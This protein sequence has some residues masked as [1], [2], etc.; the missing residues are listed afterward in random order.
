MLIVL[1]GNDMTSYFTPIPGAQGNGYSFLCDPFLRNWPLFLTSFNFSKDH[2]FVF[3][4]RVD[5]I[6]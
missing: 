3:I 1:D 6:V 2:I 5:N 4:L